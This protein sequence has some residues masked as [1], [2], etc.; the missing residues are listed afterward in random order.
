MLNPNNNTILKKK[1]VQNHVIAQ[2][3][4]A[5][6][7]ENVALMDSEQKMKLVLFMF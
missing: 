3:K 5:T 4:T 1:K 6:V 7:K 2:T